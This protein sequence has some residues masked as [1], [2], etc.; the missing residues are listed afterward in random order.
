[1][2]LRP[3][4]VVKNYLSHAEGSCLFSMGET[5][6]LCVATIENKVPP[7]IENE[8][9]NSGWVTA[10]YS[11]LPRAGKTRTPRNRGSGSGRSHEISRLIGRSL[12]GV[13]DLEQLGKRTIIIDCDVIKADGGT[14]TASVNGGYIALYL[15][16]KTLYDSTDIK[17]WPIKDSVGAVSIGIVDGKIVLDLCAKEDNN[18]EVDLNLVMTGA[19]EIIEIQGTGEKKTFSRPQLNKMIDLAS[20]GIKKIIEIEKKVLGDKR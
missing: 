16:V 19:G 5:T 1:M 12:R 17:N 4:K 14:R 10:E 2:G 11:L 9:L 7:F 18:A 6:V 13:V 8:S 15:A 3:I 20:G